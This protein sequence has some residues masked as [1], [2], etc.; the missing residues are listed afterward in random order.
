MKTLIA[1]GVTY[2]SELDEKSF[3]G[4]LDSIP[5]V[6]RYEGRGI[7][8]SIYTSDELS[9]ASIREMIS[10]F[11]RY[12]V[13]M[14]QLGQYVSEANAKWLKNKSMFWFQPIFGKG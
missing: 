5:G 4:W 8:L 6:V 3:F 2:Y 11:N 14:V 10:L 12:D 7:D 13:D 9:D 1:R